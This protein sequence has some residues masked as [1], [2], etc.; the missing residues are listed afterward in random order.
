MAEFDVVGVGLNATDTLLMVPHFPAYAGKVPYDAEVMSPGGQVAS[1]MVTCAR[2]GLRAK[3]IGTVGDDERGRIQ[4]ESLRSTGVNLD[5]VQLRKGCPNQSAYI[6]VDR[7]TGERTVLWRREDCLRIDPEE[8][9]DDQITGARLLHIDGHDTPAVAHAAAIARR[10]A[11]PVTVDVDTIYHGFDR[12]LPNVDYLV[13]SSEFP[14]NWTG[15]HDPFEAL[16]SLQDEYGMK[17]AA[18]TLGAHGALAR[19]D[20][21]FVYAPAYVVDCVDT[22]GAGDVFHGAFCYA[23]LQGMTIA[24]ALDFSNAMAALNCTAMGARGGIRGLEEIRLLMARGE[25]R[26]HPDFAARAQASG[27]APAV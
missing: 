23:V 21:Q 5:H 26:L 7:S 24:A 8:I 10:H 16:A 14:G 1:A 18:M 4:M 2:L 20:G 19:V 17:V 15:I 13:A 22:T 25:R 12:V 27:A 11:I 6:I 3:Y 9:A